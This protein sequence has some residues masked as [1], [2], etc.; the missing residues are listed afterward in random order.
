MIFPCF[1]TKQIMKLTALFL[2]LLYSG[3]G[4]GPCRFMGFGD[5][6]PSSTLFL[7]AMRVVTMR[8]D[9]TVNR[10]YLQAFRR[11]RSS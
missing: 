3:R 6:S 9:K 10:L 5:P 7:S 2:F 11:A 4:V 1:V 8:T